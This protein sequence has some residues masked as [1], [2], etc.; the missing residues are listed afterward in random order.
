M[1]FGRN[2]WLSGLSDSGRLLIIILVIVIGAVLLAL[3]EGGWKASIF[4]GILILVLIWLTKPLWT[5]S[6]PSRTRVALTSLALISSVALAMLGRTPEAKPFLSTV[7]Q[8]LGVNGTTSEKV[9][10]ADHFLSAAVLAFTLVGIY[11]VNYFLSDRTVMQR[12]PRPVDRD[13][14]EQSYRD[15]LKRYQSTLENFLNNLDEELRWDDFYLTPLD[16]EVEIKSD[17]TATRRL[18]NLMAALRND[19]TSRIM[20]VLG[21]PGAGK[22]VAL[23]STAKSL[24][25]EVGRTGRVPVYVNLKEWRADRTWTETDPPASSE[26]RAF[27]LSSLRQ[28]GMFADD[29]LGEYAD[30]MFDRG[31]FFF[32]LDSFDEIPGLLDLGEASWLVVALSKAIS[33]FVVSQ[34]DGRGIVASRFY[35]R[36]KFSH[37]GCSIFEIRPFSDLQI[38]EALRKSSQMTDEVIRE[39]F[40]VR[41]ELIPVVRNPFAATLLRIYVESHNGR[42]PGSQLEMYESYIH[43]RIGRAADKVASSLLGADELIHGSTAIAWAMFETPEIGLEASLTQLNELLPAVQVDKIT[44]ILRYANLARLGTGVDARFSFAHRRLN[45]YFVTRHFLDEPGNINLQAIPTDSRYRDALALYCEVGNTESVAAIAEFCWREISARPIA[46]SD[47]TNQVRAVHCLRFLRDAFRT[48]PE[49]IPFMRGLA[50]Y[51]QS[52][53][54]TEG[55]ILAAKLGLEAAGLLPDD[56]AEPILIDALEMEN[57]W[58]SDTCLHSCRHR[59]LISNELA[60]G[61]LRYLRELPT[62]DFLR[63]RRQL[64]FSLSLSDAF[65]KLKRYVRL[66]ALDSYGLALGMAAALV[67]SPFCVLASGIAYLFTI[68]IPPARRPFKSRLAIR[69]VARMYGACIV[70]VGTTLWLLHIGL[71]VGA[72]QAGAAG[73]RG[74]AGSRFNVL[75]FGR[76]VVPLLAGAH[77]PTRGWMIPVYLILAVMIIPVLDGGFI[78]RSA[79]GVLRGDVLGRLVAPCL[80]FG[81]GGL[82]GAC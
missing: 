79:L 82:L 69:F 20:V 74:W 49:C 36:P 65:R 1:Y 60:S 26:L 54:K 22:S 16:A 67:L 28:R 34:D 23:R 31:R 4:I 57:A 72:G 3:L 7:L 35:R 10:P 24:L 13:F 40:T 9:S 38:Q 59:Q 76:D 43:D 29:F 51:I 48:R 32:I 6:E 18:V 47:A 14:P 75:H 39:L 55:D 2:T 56:D 17:E 62:M 73:V 41:T 25:S 70:L 50:S 46:G 58:L 53:I 44:S 19:R 27:V 45:E 66:R 63:Q 37:R 11:L 77:G 68:M 61:L 21:D 42:L 64:S 12:H 52:T 30:R 81:G 5:P 8:H 71:R 78:Y 33:D 80:I 15:K